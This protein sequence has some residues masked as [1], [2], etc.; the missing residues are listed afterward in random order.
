MKLENRNNKLENFKWQ[1][2]Q[3]KTKISLILKISTNFEIRNTNY[4][5]TLLNLIPTPTLI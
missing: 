4:T 2:I 5:K 3:M 1:R